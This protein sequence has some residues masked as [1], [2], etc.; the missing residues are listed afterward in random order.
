[1]PFRAVKGMN[2]ILP[3][4]MRHWHRLEQAFLQTMRLH[5]YR[6]VR[7]PAVESTELF[8]RS[9]G[10]STDVVDKEMYTFKRESD[11]L[12]LRPEGTAGAVRAYVEHSVHARQPVTRW[13]YLGPM[14]RAENPQRGRYRQFY[15]A[16]C[17]IF[18]DPGPES[19]AEMIDM[20]CDLFGSLGIGDL[21]VSVN[22]MGGPAA[23]DRYQR[24]LSE[25]FRPRAAALSEHARR[26]LEANPLRILDSKDPRDIEASR[27]AP[28]LLDHVAEADRAHWQ[29][30]LLALDALGTPYRVE[31]RLVR[32]LA[33]P[34]E[35][36]FPFDFCG[37]RFIVRFGRAWLTDKEIISH[38]AAY[39]DR[40]RPGRPDQARPG[41][42]LPSRSPCSAPSGHPRSFGHQECFF[43]HINGEETGEEPLTKKLCYF[44]GIISKSTGFFLNLRAGKQRRTVSQETLLFSGH[45]KQDHWFLFS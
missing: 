5:G 43:L 7:T 19:D 9:I 14:F 6:E 29:G 26:R 25:Y 30:L 16:G 44:Q 1:M 24:A 45:Y 38:S 23:R 8:V 12:T 18:G 15:Q 35:L 37:L 20:L 17:E 11:S 41:E 40:G 22:C 28:E 34:G 39:R 3:E 4:E 36:F 13:Y 2:D 31:P 10:E 21:N 32:G 42:P 27:D 33:R